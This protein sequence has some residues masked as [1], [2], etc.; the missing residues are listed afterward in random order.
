M[1][2]CLINPAPP[3]SQ[4]LWPPL[5]IAYIA[6]VLEKNGCQ[7]SIIDRSAI[8]FS[9][10]LNQE[11]VDCITRD[12]LS[13][14][15]PEIVGITATTYL[16]SDAFHTSALIKEILPECIVVLG[17]T[18][19][20]ILP[21]EVLSSTPFIDLISL[22][23]GELTM[24]EL[25]E[26]KDYSNIKGIAY[27]EG[28]KFQVNER[29]NPCL[30]L[31][32]LG[33]PARHLLDMKFY[34]QDSS[35]I[36]R[37]IKLKGTHVVSSRGCPFKCIF[38]AGASVFGKK[39]RFHSV[40]HVIQEVEELID[41]Y[42]VEGIYFAEDMFLSDKK[43]AHQICDAFINRDLNKKIVWCA[44]LH[45]NAVDVS[46]LEKM[47]SAGCIQVEYGFESGS[48][49][50]LDRMN[51]KSTVEKNI[52]IAQLTK[53][54]GLRVLANIIVGMPEETE[55]DFFKTIS[56]M[57]KI[58]AEVVGFNKCVP[59]PGSQIYAELKAKGQISNNLNDY[60]WMHDNHYMTMD[61]GKFKKEFRRYKDKLDRRY[62]WVCFKTNFKRHP[63]VVFET[64]KFYVYHVTILGIK[65]ILDI[66]GV[67]DR[68]KKI[69]VKKY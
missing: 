42:K 69:L 17:G 3:Q 16:I 60:F 47:K 65:F 18:H 32:D 66:F 45:V 38:C 46:L 29:R 14:L 64:T 27:R 25:S 41:E 62:Y 57:E 19:A 8:K 28:D 5:G 21:E 50:T 35:Q 39:V 26:R 31:D 56:F 52:E 30:N 37:G 43:R 48:Q 15:R 9:S 55:E 23:E 33:R 6:S 22:G 54:V 59:L 11:K 7:V 10:N 12:T 24:L 49:L 68:V 4:G 67:R 51:K 13:R 61:K 34:L 58:Q 20:S 2:I 63:E 1:K 36:I 40:E 44:Q 53:R